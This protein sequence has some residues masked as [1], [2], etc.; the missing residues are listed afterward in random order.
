MNRHNIPP[1]DFRNGD[2]SSATTIIY[3]PATGNADGTGPPALPGQRH[4]RQPDQPHRAEPPGLPA[5]PQR[6]APPSARTTTSSR[7]CARRRR[8]PSTSSS[9][10]RPPTEDSLSYRFSFQRPEVFDPGTFGIY[11][12][13]SNGG[14]AGTGTNKTFSTALNW[15]RTFGSSAILDVRGGFVYYHNEALAQG[16]GLNTS[17]EVGISGANLDDFTSGLTQIEIQQRLLGPDAR[18]LRQHALG[19]LG[20]DLQRGLHLHQDQGQPHR[21]GGL[22]RPPQSR[23]PAPGPGQRRLARPVPVQR[24]PDRRLRRTP[25]PRTATPTPWRASCSTCPSLRLPRPEGHGP[26]HAAL[27]RLHLHPRQVAGDARS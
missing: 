5:R 27:G 21:Q 4:P 7:A 10:T 16:A 18:L 12:G 23:L 15:T 14:F 22:R 26:R 2:F 19:P 11:G 25:R 3:D 6:A 17:D 9:P 24:G 1:A 13:P 8:R 20:E